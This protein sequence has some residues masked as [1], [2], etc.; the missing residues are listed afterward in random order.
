MRIRNFRWGVAALGALALLTGCW[1][2][3]ELNELSIVAGMG[4]DAKDERV[5]VSVQIVNPSEV[6]AKNGGGK[7]SPPVTTLKVTEKTTVEALR[8][9]TVVSPRRIYTS[10]LRILVIG[11]Q[12]ARQGVI[13]VMD[14]ISRNHEIRSDFYLIVAKDA[15][16][17]KVLEVLTP[18]EK[19]P[20]NKLFD[21][22]EISDKLWAPTVKIELDR[23][24]SDL[25]NPTR[26][27]VL[28]GIE[29]AGDA[30][31]GETEE[32]MERVYPYSNLKYSGIAMFKG[33]KLIGWLTEEESKGYNYIMGNVKNSAGRLACPS[34][35][36]V[37]GVEVIRTQSDV[38]GKVVGGKPEIRIDLQV[39]EDIGEVQCDIDLLKPGTIEKLER[40]SNEKIKQMMESAIRK[41]QENQTDIFGFGDAI[42]DANPAAWQE[43]KKEWD[44][45]F[46]N[47]DVTIQVDARF[48]R[49]GTTTEPLVQE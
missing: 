45:H 4:L 26:D 44:S 9:L 30:E 15:T 1:D 36:G 25:T 49:Y 43:L 41:A 28:T 23:F 19:I 38:T 3:R 42:E 29:I 8:K 5:Q 40:R 14:G 32:N 27:P 7:F 12:L 6:A 10:H 35:E 34:G 39:E 24:V 48:R 17:E 11:E 33:D 37:I 47:L 46:T 18:I 31:K 21:T 2:R 13:K 16:A 20:A 22:L